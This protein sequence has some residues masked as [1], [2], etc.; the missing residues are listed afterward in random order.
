MLTYTRGQLLLGRARYRPID[1]RACYWANFV[2]DE[3]REIEVR[4]FSEEKKEDIVGMR[5]LPIPLTDQ[6]N[7]H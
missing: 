3:V 1:D 4:K 7:Y 2:L 5:T 6:C